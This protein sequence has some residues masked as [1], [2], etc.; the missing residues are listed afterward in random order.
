VHQ[1]KQLLIDMPRFIVEL[2]G[3]GYKNFLQVETVRNQVNSSDSIRNQ[4]EIVGDGESEENKET[5]LEK[6]DE[7]KP[8]ETTRLHL[9]SLDDNGFQMKPPE[10]TTEEANPLGQIL[11]SKN[12]VIDTLKKEAEHL[13]NANSHLLEQNRELTQMTHLLVA[14]KENIQEGGEKEPA[15]FTRLNSASV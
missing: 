6:S 3:M 15:E 12:E 1:D 9:K 11:E 5:V 2:N 8:N 14:P 10:S 7:V 4:S 13:R